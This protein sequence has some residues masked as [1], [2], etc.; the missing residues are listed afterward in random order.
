M[1]A[2]KRLALALVGAALAFALV[3]SILRSLASDETRVRWLVEEL[4]RD[5]NAGD[6]GDVGAKLH[7]DYVDLGTGYGRDVVQEA[8]LY[9]VF[10]DRE[11]G[12]KG[13]RYRVEIDA[14]A[15][16]V[17]VHDSDPRTADATIRADLFRRTGET[18]EPYW[19]AVVPTRF[20]KGE[21][22]WK[23]VETHD[24]NHADRSR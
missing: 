12:T 24:V 10:Q 5:F 17:R 14:D 11:P 4:A 21:N 13:F 3:R 8:L 9:L 15:L 18:E 19:N 2:L 1:S 22:G 7:A 6:A 20:A 16:E 23:I